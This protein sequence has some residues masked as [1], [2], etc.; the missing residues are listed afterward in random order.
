MKSRLFQTKR[1]ED[2]SLEAAAMTHGLKRVLGPWHLIFLGIGAIVGELL[3]IGTLLAWMLIGFV[4]SFAYGIRKSKLR[5]Q[6][7]EP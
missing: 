6:K 3:S 7:S 4:V 1:L 2:L 5:Q